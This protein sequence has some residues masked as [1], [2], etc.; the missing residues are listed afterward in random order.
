MQELGAEPVLSK[1]GRINKQRFDVHNNEYVTKTRTILDLLESG[2]TDASSTLHRPI[3]P[4]STDAVSDALELAA[5]LQ[6]S[7]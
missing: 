2:I 7:E 1:L 3:L 4:R 6:P 5:D